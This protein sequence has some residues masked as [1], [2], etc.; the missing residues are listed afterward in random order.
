MRWTTHPYP[1]TDSKRLFVIGSQPRGELVRY[2]SGLQQTKP[3]LSGAWATGLDF[4]PDGTSLVYV[5]YPDATLWRSKADGTERFQLTNRP[6]KAELPR[7][8]P[9]GRR[10]AFVGMERGGPWR[11]YAISPEGGSQE[12][13]VASDVSECD[14]GWS[15]DGNSLVF[16]E[17]GNSTGTSAVRVLD[18]ETRKTSTLPGSDGLFSPRWS[19]DGRF[20][21]AVTMA[22]DTKSPAKLLLFDFAT[23]QWQE[24]LRGHDAN[25]AVWSRNGKYIYFSDPNGASVPFYQVRVAD[26][27]LQRMADVSL[28]PRGPAW[29]RF[30][31]WTGLSPDG[32]P[33][34]LRDA[35]IYEIYALELQLP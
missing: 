4:S 8:S 5:S 19:P 13:L 7:W 25:C 17:C 10:I 20:I 22:W 27:K 15:P 34:M 24:L 3:Y 21:A 16:A 2:D 29:T 9:D 6:M 31:I 14:P 26:H 35:S 23:K 11:V 33:L 18:L 32:S 1:S 30:G 28:L 12:L